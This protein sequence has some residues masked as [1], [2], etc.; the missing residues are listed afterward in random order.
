MADDD[1]EDIDFDDDGEEQSD[2]QYE[3]SRPPEKQ[4]AQARR[5]LERRLELKRLREMIDYAEFDDDF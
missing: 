4:A 1:I 3:D 5:E 2:I